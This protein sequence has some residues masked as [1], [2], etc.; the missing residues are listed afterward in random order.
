MAERWVSSREMGQWQRGRLVTEVSQWQRD[1]LVAE[2]G[3]DVERKVRGKVV[4]ARKE[5]A[6][7]LLVAMGAS[8][9]G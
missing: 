1:G 3:R 4:A 2:R 9:L 5:L 6:G 8:H 7:R